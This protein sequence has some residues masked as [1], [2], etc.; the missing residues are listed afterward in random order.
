M[1]TTVMNKPAVIQSYD[2][3]GNSTFS[4][5]LRPGMLIVGCRRLD[6]SSNRIMLMCDMNL[7]VVEFG[8]INGFTYSVSSGQLSITETTGASCRITVIA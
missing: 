7:N 3:G 6:S 4:I 2:K 8:Q 5:A 1:S